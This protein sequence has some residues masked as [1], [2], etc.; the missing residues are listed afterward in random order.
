MMLELLVFFQAVLIV[1]KLSGVIK[2]SWRKVIFLPL[3]VILAWFILN[4]LIITGAFGFLGLLEIAD[5]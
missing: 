2:C 3:L 5:F 1:L 4:V